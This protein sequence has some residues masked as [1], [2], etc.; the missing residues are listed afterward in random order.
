MQPLRH[1]NNMQGH[2]GCWWDR[3][4]NAWTL[5]GR[6]KGSLLLISCSMDSFSHKDVFMLY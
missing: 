3:A 4:G 2:H 5:L 1:F 6:P